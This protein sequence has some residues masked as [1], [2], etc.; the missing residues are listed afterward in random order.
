MDSI[1]HVKENLVL[2]RARTF[3]DCIHW[4]R[5]QFEEFFSNTIKQLLFNFPIDTLTSSGTPFWSGSKK[6]PQPIEFDPNDHTHMMF[7]VAAANLRAYTFGLHVWHFLFF[8][9]ILWISLFIFALS[10][11]SHFVFLWE[12]VPK[13]S[14]NEELFHRVLTTSEITPF[15]PRQGV[16]IAITE[17]EAEEC[18]SHLSLSKI[19]VPPKK[20]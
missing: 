8:S 5:I 1:N 10:H 20:K 7:V 18:L 9:S 2:Y 12:L 4:A 16:K 6:P 17:A 13:G 15:V 11:L 19:G 3:E 14:K